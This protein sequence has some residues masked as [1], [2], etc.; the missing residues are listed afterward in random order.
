MSALS[1]FPLYLR[2]YTFQG[3]NFFNGAHETEAHEVGAREPP[4]ALRPLR[5][6]LNPLLLRGPPRGASQPGSLVGPGA[7]PG[8]VREPHRHRQAH[9]LQDRLFQGE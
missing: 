7:P 2:A 8:D 1:A 6:E 4:D 9:R 5:V 3:P